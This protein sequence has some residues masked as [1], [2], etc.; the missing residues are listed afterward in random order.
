MKSFKAFLDELSEND[1]A[2]NN[3]SGGAIAG[4]GIG[5]DGTPPVRNR[6]P[7]LL[8]RRDQKDA[9]C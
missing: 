4:V 3:V 9:I 7:K 8:K 5:P 1:V 2:V 6:K